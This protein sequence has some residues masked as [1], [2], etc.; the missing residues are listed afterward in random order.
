MDVRTCCYACTNWPHHI[1]F[2]KNKNTYTR[3]HSNGEDKYK[4]KHAM[5]S[6]YINIQND[7][8]PKC[9]RYMKSTMRAG[10]T[11]QR[12]RKTYRATKRNLQKKNKKKQ[13]SNKGF[14]NKLLSRL[15]FSSKRFFILCVS[16]L[17][18]SVCRIVGIWFCCVWY[19]WPMN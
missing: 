10:K 4:Q 15:K 8:L 11:P 19:V 16:S 17:F 7:L 2:K 1:Y 9:N 13:T 3:T 5:S 14:R 12:I 18:A 6:A